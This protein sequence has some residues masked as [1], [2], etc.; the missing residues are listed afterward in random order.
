MFLFALLLA[1]LCIRA[2]VRVRVCAYASV[3][4]PAKVLLFFG[5]TKYFV[6]K[7]HFFYGGVRVFPFVE[8]WG[9][10]L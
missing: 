9:E 5:T 8:G 10:R 1:F 6:R 7:I 3:I 4:N 2:R